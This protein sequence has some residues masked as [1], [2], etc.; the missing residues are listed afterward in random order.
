MDVGMGVGAV[1]AVG[2]SGKVGEGVCVWVARGV[3]VGSGVLVTVAVG[4]E[5]VGWKVAVAVGSGAGVST[6]PANGRMQRHTKII[7]KR[8]SLK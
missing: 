6:Q 1:V 2:I 3:A 7:G 5:I 8:I 4:N